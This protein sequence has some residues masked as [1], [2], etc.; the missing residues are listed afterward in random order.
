MNSPSQIDAPIKQAHHDDGTLKTSSEKKKWLVTFPYPYMNGRL[1][2][3]HAFSLTKAEFSARFRTLEGRKVLWPFGFHC[4]GMPICAA[5]LKLEKV[6][7]W[8]VLCLFGA[9]AETTL[10]MYLL[11]PQR[12]F[13]F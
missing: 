5:A 8:G 4:T 1:H 11:L 3:G 12:R 6:K 2:L 7:F 10:K 13:T 9:V